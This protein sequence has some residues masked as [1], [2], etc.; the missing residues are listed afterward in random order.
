MRK[1]LAILKE[2]SPNAVQINTYF[3]TISFLLFGIA[4]AA[5]SQLAVQVLAG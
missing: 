2:K 5:S 1:V 4:A 3:L